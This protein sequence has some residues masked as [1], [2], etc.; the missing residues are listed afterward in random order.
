[1]SPG[2]PESPMCPPPLVENSTIFF[3]FLNPSLLLFGAPNNLM[4]DLFPD[5]CR[6]FGTQPPGNHFGLDFTVGAG[7]EQVPPAL[8]IWDIG[9]RTWERAKDQILSMFFF[10]R[11]P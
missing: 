3:F 5:P 1:M 10:C 2:G 4:S 7:G 11:I 9:Y 8:L 6:H